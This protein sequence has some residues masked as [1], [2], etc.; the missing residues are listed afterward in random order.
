[1]GMGMGMGLRIDLK[2]L[3]DLDVN[4][5][6]TFKNGYECRYNS[7]RPIPVP[8]PSLTMDFFFLLKLDKI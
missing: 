7:T 8:C 6:M 1:M 2:N 5:G 4:M 3:M